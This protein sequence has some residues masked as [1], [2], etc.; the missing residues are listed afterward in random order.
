MRKKVLDSVR[1]KLIQK[2][3]D[4][5]EMF[6]KDEIEEIGERE[7]DNVIGDIVDRANSSYEMQVSDRLSEYEQQ[8]LQEIKDALVRIDE[9]VYGK[10]VS[11]GQAI[12][13]KRLLAMPEAKMCVSCKA[14][15]EKR[16]VIS[17]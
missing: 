8:K 14:K 9:G 15:Q 16:G 12:S 6:E 4:I 11:C 5:L 17:R 13:E 2:M 7:S 10:C 1:K 3:N